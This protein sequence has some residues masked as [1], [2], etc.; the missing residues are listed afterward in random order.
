MKAKTMYVYSGNQR[1]TIEI[2]YS[3]ERKEGER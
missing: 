3:Y 2:K 1:E